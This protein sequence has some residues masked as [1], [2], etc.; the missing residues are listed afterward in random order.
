[1]ADF[2]IGIWCERTWTDRRK[3]PVG[4]LRFQCLAERKSLA[5][6]RRP[7][8][9]G[10]WAKWVKSSHPHQEL[11]KVRIVALLGDF[12]FGFAEQKPKKKGR[13]RARFPN[14]VHFWWSFTTKLE[15]ISSKM[16]KLSPARKTL[17]FFWDF[18]RR[19]SFWIL[20]RVFSGGSLSLCDTAQLALC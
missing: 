14:F 20:K 9:A 4:N 13:F 3:L 17:C 19:I 7:A 6:K 15:P 16:R 11:T 8:L 2:W 1:M 12:F 10:E 18:P 5:W